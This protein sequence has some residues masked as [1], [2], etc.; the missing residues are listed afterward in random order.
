MDGD[1]EGVGKGMWVQMGKV[2]VMGEAVGIRI[3][4]GMNVGEAKDGVWKG[5]CDEKGVEAMDV[6]KRMEKGMRIGM[7]KIGMEKGL[8]I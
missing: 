2:M 3:W 1:D 6:W 4:K 5:L 8:D 7:I